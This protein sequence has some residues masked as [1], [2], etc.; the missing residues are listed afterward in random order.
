MLFRTNHPRLATKLT[1][2]ET[3]DHPVKC[4]SISIDPALCHKIWNSFEQTNK[5]TQ[6]QSIVECSFILKNNPPSICKKQTFSI[7][8]WLTK[9]QWKIKIE[10]NSAWYIL[11]T[12]RCCE[13]TKM[14][15][16]KATFIHTLPKNSPTNEDLL[17]F[18]W[19]WL[20]QI[21]GNLPSSAGGHNN[22]LADKYLH[23]SQA[24]NCIY[25]SR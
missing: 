10:N 12:R 15:F 17:N 6:Q 16:I 23:E 9:I 20:T 18:I 11:W 1:G 14:G 24:C 7:F 3:W 8:Y 21:K 25:N 22:G 5:L 4:L 19:H 2:L 13:I